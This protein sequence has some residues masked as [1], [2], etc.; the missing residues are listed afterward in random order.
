MQV[1]PTAPTGTTRAPGASISTSHD[2]E[3]ALRRAAEDIEVGFL[4]EMLKHSGLGE[5]GESFGGG[6]GEEQFA[7]FLREEQ[8][9]AM[10]QKGG[11]GLAEQI[12]LSMKRIAENG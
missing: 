1:L 6:I 3:V 2:R 11:V 9:R 10:V 12:F 8:A 7:S 5:T 4:T